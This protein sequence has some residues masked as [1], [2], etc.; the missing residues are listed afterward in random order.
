MA[1]FDHAGNSALR[2]RVTLADETRDAFVLF[3]GEELVDKKPVAPGSRL[4]LAVSQLPGP[5]QAAPPD[6]RLTLT[7][8]GASV[9]RSFSLN[10]DRG[11]W[12]EREFPL[13]DLAGQNVT[14][15]IQLENPAAPKSSRPR[16]ALLIGN[17]RL[18]EPRPANWL[19]L[20]LINLDIMPTALE[21]LGV[22]APANL[23]GKSLVPWLK[24]PNAEGDREAF[25]SMQHMYE[26]GHTARSLREV[27]RKLILSTNPDSVELYNLEQDPG[28]THNLAAAEPEVVR[29]LFARVTALEHQMQATAVGAPLNP[30]D[31]ET[32]KLLQSL[33][34]LE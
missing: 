1:L 23:E 18:V 30:P 32:L 34:Y 12:Q 22:P 14:L 31:A 29:S 4:T 2:K 20:I 13:D 17:P 24:D 10:P 8:V 3:P 5:S 6:Y 11:S 19:N 21:L 15:R 7:L 16:F 9:T 25:A 27:G 28:E 33:G 26:E